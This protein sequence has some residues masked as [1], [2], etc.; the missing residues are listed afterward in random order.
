[1][2]SVKLKGIWDWPAPTTVKEVQPFL[3][4]GN[5]YRKFINKFLELA[6]VRGQVPQILSTSP[7]SLVLFWIVFYSMQSVLTAYHFL[8]THVAHARAL[9]L[10]S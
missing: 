2:D 8:H 7:V 10:S 3:G 1:M 4:F 9:T 6:A 5:F